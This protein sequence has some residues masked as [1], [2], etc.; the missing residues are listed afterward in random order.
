MIDKKMQGILKAGI[1]K[2]IPV[3]ELVKIEN[4]ILYHTNLSTFTTVQNVDIENG[5]YDMKLLFSGVKKPIPD[6]GKFPEFPE[7]Q[8]GRYIQSLTKEESRH[9][10]NHTKDDVTRYF[11]NGIHVDNKATVSTDGRRLTRKYWNNN[12]LENESVFIPNKYATGKLLQKF[13]ET[14]ATALSTN[15]NGEWAKIENGDISTVFKN[16]EYNKGQQF[17]KYEQVFPEF[18]NPIKVYFPQ[19]HVL[20]GALSIMKARKDKGKRLMIVQENDT[21]HFQIPEYSTE[22][23]NGKVEYSE[24]IL[25]EWKSGSGKDK[26]EFKIAINVE[27]LFDCSRYESPEFLY[28]N[29]ERHNKPV[30]IKQGAYDTLIMPMQIQV[31]SIYSQHMVTCTMRTMATRSSTC[32]CCSTT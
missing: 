12:L 20:S 6:N 22:G 26:R 1:E 24:N 11:M 14:Y 25:T 32:S 18:K 3:S 21:I 10:F 28:I 4:G 15:V 9:L 13:M 23:Y 8:G 5:F 2:R 30:W 19:F 16:L 17:P 31:R 29:K 7:F 27:Y